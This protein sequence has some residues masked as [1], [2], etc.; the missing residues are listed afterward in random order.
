MENAKLVAIGV[1]LMFTAGV[2]NAGCEDIE[3]EVRQ[4]EAHEAA[5]MWQTAAADYG[6]ASDCYDSVAKDY[7]NA[8][9]YGKKAAEMYEKA[10]IMGSVAGSH[11]LIAG[12]YS[13]KGEGNEDEIREHCSIGEQIFLEEINKQLQRDKPDYS[14]V[15]SNYRSIADC[16]NLIDDREKSCGYCAE[17]NIYREKR[18]LELKDCKKLYECS[19]SSGGTNGGNPGGG[20]GGNPGGG[21]S[22]GGGSGGGGELPVTWIA[23]GAVV[24]IVIAGATWFFMK[25]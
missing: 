16:Y 25:R 2:V 9:K 6:S 10:G 7:D 19:T 15:Y 1:F 8:I 13:K 24:L 4:G 22:G 12:Y 3:S 14:S 11:M 17:M 23:I 5:E 21:T 18:A 20:S